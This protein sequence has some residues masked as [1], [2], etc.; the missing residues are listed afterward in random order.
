MSA[1]R[2]FDFKEQEAFIQ[3]AAFI[4]FVESGAVWRSRIFCQSKKSSSCAK[5]S[6][7]PWFQTHVNKL[8]VVYYRI[9]YYS[10]TSRL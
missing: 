7:V 1:M 9:H 4:S 5:A 6:N 3:G 2:A 8:P 10:S